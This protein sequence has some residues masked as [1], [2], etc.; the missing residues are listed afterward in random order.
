[1]FDGDT[2]KPV[3]P[4]V[5]CFIRMTCSQWYTNFKRNDGYESQRNEMNMSTSFQRNDGYELTIRMKRYEM[6]S[7]T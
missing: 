6:N 7:I 2:A 3:I 5:S 4:V 1:M